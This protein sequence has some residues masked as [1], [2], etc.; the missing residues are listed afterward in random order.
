MRIFLSFRCAATL[1]CLLLSTGGVWAQSKPAAAAHATEAQNGKDRYKGESFVVERN[2]WVYQENGDGTG[3]RE[4]T[5]AVRLQSEAAL[6]GFGVV[7]V[8]FASA[9]EH[10]EFHYARVRRASGTVI[11]T[12]ATD[13]IEQPEP[14]TREAPFYS[15]LKSAQLP[16]KNLQVGDVL[17]WQARVVRARGEAPGHFW[18][19]EAKVAD[20]MVTLEQ[21]VELRAPAN[22][23]VTVWT[24]PKSDKPA[25]SSEG[26]QH[27]WRWKSA[28]LTPTTGP[29]AEAAKKAKQNKVLTADEQKDQ[30][31]GA[32]PW[33][34]W[35]NFKSWEDVGAWYRGLEGKRAE[36]DDEIRQQVAQLTA[37]STTEEDKVRAVYAFVSARV[38]Y[39]GVAFG[40]GR[41]QPHEAAD[42]LHNQYGDCKDKATLL[43]AALSAVGLHPDTVLIGQEIR[44]NEAVPSPASFNHAI[45][46]VKVGDKEVWLD[47]TQEVGPYQVLLAPLRDKQAL[48]VPATGPAALE[49]TPKDLPFPAVVTWKAVGKLDKDGISES[50]ISTSFRGD[51]EVILRAA[52]H[53]FAPAQ[54]DDLGQKF[55]GSLG[56]SG[57]T[58]HVSFSRPEETVDPFTFDVDYHREKAGDWD[59]L[60]TVPQ[61]APVELPRVDEKDPPV[62]EFRIGA[63]EEQRSHSEMKLPDGWTAELPEAVHRKSAWAD[64]DMTFKFENGTVIA[65]RVLVIKQ[66]KV[67]AADWK[68]YKKFTDDISVGYE[69]YVQLIRAGADGKALARGSASGHVSNVDAEKLIQQ[70]FD[71]GRGMDVKS[72]EGLLKQ[73]KGLD[74]DARRLWDAFGYLALLRGKNN[75]AI[76]DFRKELTLYPQAFE[77]YQ[78]MAQAQWQHNDKA[79]AETTA[80]QWAAA[81]PGD[82][83]AQQVLAAYLME[84]NQPGDA[85]AAAAK[86]LELTGADDK[87]N[88]QQRTLLLGRALLKA[89]QN[90]KAQTTLVSLLNETDNPL[91]MN[92]AAYELADARLELPL[93][94]KKVREALKKM[95]EKTSAWTLDERPEALKATSSL[96]AATWDTMGWILYREGKVQEARTYIQAAWMNQHHKEVKGHLDQI[97]DELQKT[98]V[99]GG[100]K[101][102]LED[103]TVALGPYSGP[104]MVAE[105]KLLLAHGKVE[106]DEPVGDKAVGGA[107]G[108]LKAA[109]FASLFPEGSDAKLVRMGMVN[110]VGGKCEIVLEP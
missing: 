24:N 97:D 98:H 74:P 56:Y 6:R 1:F 19:S 20:G 86:S 76:D 11:E 63:V 33:L 31:E 34:A 12:P 65:E 35:T 107:D 105:Y 60:K 95:D 68:E 3:Y 41:F 7:N 88:H 4:H 81:N 91:Y 101:S 30:D 62:A 90:T 5:V 9:T 55:M 44:M 50:H 69:P 40:V 108:M 72:A 85:A 27:V 64:Y 70:A 80:R 16:I 23:F 22:A 53:Q 104:K 14:V 39:V 28:Q 54:Y 84:D 61:L 77:A 47:A 66:S 32:L 29:E 93:D 42:V 59:N 89:G 79:G 102:D 109:S 8:E 38:R 106:R 52:V 25:E 73:A 49:R 2:D 103:R 36:P 96:L 43:A 37:K 26:D 83:R 13:V 10:V 15:D 18:G 57:T 92:D 45:T 67:A 99:A 100:R 58:S 17:E 82:A 78:F 48:V 51:E 21:T 71:A 46:R 110:C 87:E 75:E 94:E